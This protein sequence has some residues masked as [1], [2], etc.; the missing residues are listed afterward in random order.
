MF[1]KLLILINTKIIAILLNVELAG[2]Y[3]FKKN[4]WRGLTPDS[5][6]VK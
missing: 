2:C 4:M 6:Y 3:Y 1:E 5:L